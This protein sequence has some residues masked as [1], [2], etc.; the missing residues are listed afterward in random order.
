LASRTQRAAASAQVAPSNA[1]AASFGA[2]YGK[3]FHRLSWRPAQ[4][5]Y[6]LTLFPEATTNRETQNN[7]RVSAGVVFHL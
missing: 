7:L 3:L 4:V 6:F 2:V 1:F 5:E